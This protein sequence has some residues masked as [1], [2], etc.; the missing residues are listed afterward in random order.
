MGYASTQAWL[1]GA[2]IML[3][4]VINFSLARRWVFYETDTAS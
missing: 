3:I 2:I 1:L 4:T